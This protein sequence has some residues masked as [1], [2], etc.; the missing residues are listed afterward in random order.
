MSKVSLLDLD[1]EY[2]SSPMELLFRVLWFSILVLAVRTQEDDVNI[3]CPFPE[4]QTVAS[5]SECAKYLACAWT[6]G[7][8]HMR[9]NAEAGYTVVG[10]SLPTSRGYQVNLKKIDPY[11]TLFDNDIQDLVLEIIPHGEDHVQIKI[12]DPTEARYEVP[13]PLTLP[14]EVGNDSQYAV[15]VSA[16]GD[17][18]F[19]SVGR[20]LP[21]AEETLFSTVGAITF[22]DQFLQFTTVL[23]TEYLYGLGENTHVTIKHSFESRATRPLFAKDQP[24]GDTEVN[25]YSV[26]PYYINVNNEAGTSHSVLFFNSN[27]M[28]YSTFK[29]SDG[30]P[31]LIFRSIGGIIDLHFFLGPS[32]EEVNIQYAN[33]VGTPAFPPYWSL[34]FQLSRYGY[35]GVA[36][37]RE[38]RERMKAEGIPQDVQTLDIDY[39]LRF[40]DFTYDTDSWGDLPEFV[41]ELHNDDVKVTLILDPAL[42]IDFDNYPPS[43]RGKEA[44]AFVKWMSED[45]VPED[46]EPGCDSYIIGYVWPDTKTL[47]PDFFKPATQEWWTN[48]LK[49]LHD[50]LPY[51]AIW[52]D[53]NEPA[54]FGT[55]LDRP[56][57]YPP[58]KPDWSLKCPYNKWDSPPYPTKMVRTGGSESQRISEKTICMS[59]NH[60]DGSQ[61]FLHY[62]VHNLYGWSETVATYKGLEEVFT[63][64]RQVVLSRSTYPG[65]GRYA[66]H[67]LGD[68]VAQWDHLRYS[69]VGMVEFNFFALPMVGADVCGFFND[70]T[71]ELCARWMQLGAFSPFDRNHNSIDQEDQDPAHWPE[72]AAISRDVLSLRYQYLPY[73]Y[74]LFHNAHHYGQS[75]LR[76]I[77]SEFLTD[78]EALDVSDQFMWG[79]GIMV[80]PVMYEGAVDRD[81][82][83]PQGDW[84]DLKSGIK[85]A[86]GPTSI[87]IDAPLEKIPVYVRGG[88]ILPYQEPALNTVQSRKNPFG[89]TVAL[90]SSQSAS[91]EIYWDD[92]EAVHEESYV[93]VFTANT[94]FT[95]NILTMEVMHSMTPVAGLNIETLQVFGY[96]ANP[97][98]IEVN[99][100]SLPSSQWSY[101]ASS[102]VLVVYISAPLGENLTVTFEQ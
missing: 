53:M 40:R 95:N 28:E 51:D 48:E 68:N 39:M 71:M 77:F 90:D 31:A 101:E 70:P 76:P 35:K 43:Q 3:E 42:A 11:M 96:P 81:V 60:T 83:F 24:V 72:V 49:I 18:F 57:N 69:V 14:E 80:A 99:G 17:P 59:G 27:A 61:T 34:G 9:S 67:W 63:G 89:L 52:I 66:V 4:G 23:P 74:A 29:L 97:E 92:G 79:T 15:T 5:E 55:N 54:N 85:E 73:L 91:G 47:F 12:Y 44:D 64:K 62:D 75:V 13:V 25:H 30:R 16:P 98:V 56:W 37:V 6:D 58:E 7:V 32:L 102:S 26:H 1:R 22:E 50:T 94:N 45:L 21:N 86:T 2:L 88:V 36:D 65:S 38:V 41:E 93:D 33:T 100:E 8:C 46:Q 82:Y 19:F 78:E 84:Y 87:N 10:D 20:R